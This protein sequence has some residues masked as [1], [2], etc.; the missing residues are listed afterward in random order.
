MENVVIQFSENDRLNYQ[1]K[2]LS[3]RNTDIIYKHL[4][5]LNKSAS[6]PK[7]MISDNTTVS[8]LEEKVNLL[9]E[10][11]HSVFSQKNKV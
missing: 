1:N 11:F 3:T 6:L 7:R 10:F 5:S 9:N 4:K 8:S 2:L